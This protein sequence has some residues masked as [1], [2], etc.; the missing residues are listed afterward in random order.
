[1]P[2]SNDIK[3]RP[4]RLLLESIVFVWWYRARYLKSLAIPTLI[5]V[6]IWALSIVFQDQLTRF[7]R[8]SYWILYQVGFVFFAVACHRLVLLNESNQPLASIFN[9]RAAIF[10]FWSF[11]I[12]LSSVVMMG[13]LLN[14]LINVPGAV[15][16]FKDHGNFFWIQVVTTLPAYYLIGRCILVLPATAIDEAIGL[17]ESWQRTRG[18]GWKIVLIIGI[19]PWIINV[20]LWLAAGD[21]TTLFSYSLTAVLYYVGLALEV[22]ALSFVYK[23]LVSETESDAQSD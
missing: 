16:L 21:E 3:L 20:I 17:R 4:L 18:N 15:S 14:L 9:K 2:D 11:G 1:M 8:W 10:L 12:L 13:M 23:A 6:V 5:L 7:S 22:T 19:Y